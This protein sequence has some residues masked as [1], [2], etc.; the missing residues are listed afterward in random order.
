MGKWIQK[1]QDF[2]AGSKRFSR[3]VGIAK[4][5]PYD[6]IKSRPVSLQ[7]KYQ[8]DSNEQRVDEVFSRLRTY[9]VERVE[10]LNKQHRSP[11]VVFKEAGRFPDG[12]PYLFFKPANQR[13]WLIERQGAGWIVTRAEKI[14]DR[15]LFLRGT[16][17]V[18]DSVVLY[19]SEQSNSP[20]IS[21]SKFGGDL[22]AFTLYEQRFAEALSDKMIQGVS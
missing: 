17:D 5:A 1:V 3:E 2:F 15:A 4:R 9:L 8:V 22:L 21:S 16:Q 6:L 13:G 11:L 19:S 10:T 20:R 12:R 18:W 14:I 7:N